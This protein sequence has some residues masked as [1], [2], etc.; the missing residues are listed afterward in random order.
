M[1]ELSSHIHKLDILDGN[2]HWIIFCLALN[3]R[4][5]CI[6]SNFAGLM[7]GNL[8]F[9]QKLSILNDSVSGR[10]DNKFW[11]IV[12]FNVHFRK[13]FS[14]K[15]KLGSNNNM[16]VSSTKKLLHLETV[17]HQGWHWS[18]LLACPQILRSPWEKKVKKKKC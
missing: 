16:I 7:H 3:G 4:A 8:F 11:Q 17:L 13:C 18:Y 12:N 10:G 15:G 5:F 1:L 14:L 9:Y 2:T 6:L